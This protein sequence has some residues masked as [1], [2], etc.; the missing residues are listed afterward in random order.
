MK[1]FGFQNLAMVCE[2]DL[3]RFKEAEW[4][5]RGA[6]D[7]LS[8]A[9]VFQRLEEA[10]KPV[11]LVIGMTSRRGNRLR[12]TLKPEEMAEILAGSWDGRPAAL[13][14]GPED[15]G[16]SVEERNR[17]DWVVRIPTHGDCPSMNLSHAVTVICYVLSRY[18]EKKTEDAG[19]RPAPPEELNRLL[20][21]AERFL[22]SRGFVTGDGSRDTAPLRRFQ[23]MLI[24]CAPGR[25][26]L[27]LLWALLRHLERQARR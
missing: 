5:A 9:S 14:F 27:K 17:C 4:M 20:D 1:N 18:G 10:L 8:S 22:M 7:L 6:L 2:K 3:H 23:R 21:H 26:E 19:V 13:L 12:E 15:R 16:L 24:R 11:N 25:A